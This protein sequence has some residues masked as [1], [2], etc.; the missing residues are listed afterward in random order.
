[1]V[2]ALLVLLILS[3]SEIRVTVPAFL[4]DGAALA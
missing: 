2:K 4:A 3:S 1:M